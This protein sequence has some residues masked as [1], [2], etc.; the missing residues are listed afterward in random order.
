MMVWLRDTIPNVRNS[1]VYAQPKFGLGVNCR[2]WL[3]KNDRMYIKDKED[4][5]E[6]QLQPATIPRIETSGGCNLFV[7]LGDPASDISHSP[8]I[9]S[10]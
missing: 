10:K 9:E 6:V 8:A 1:Y 4:P 2:H 5:V 3:Y 7:P